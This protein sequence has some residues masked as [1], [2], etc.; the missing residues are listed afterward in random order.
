MKGACLSLFDYL[1]ADTHDA[2]TVL[3][4]FMKHSSAFKSDYV[5]LPPSP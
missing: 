5:E 1:P 4:S 2:P 3:P